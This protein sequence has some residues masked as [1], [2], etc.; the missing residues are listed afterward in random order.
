MYFTPTH[1]FKD[2]KKVKK[3]C[4]KVAVEVKS[5]RLK[6]DGSVNCL[7]NKMTACAANYIHMIDAYIC[8]TVNAAC[9]KSGINVS[10]IH[11]CWAVNDKYS[12][13]L[14]YHYKRGCV[15]KKLM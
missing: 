8:H 13:F 9:V 3:K 12:S 7:A 5:P 11:D 15:F 10:S 14:M 1:V 4:V 2:Q 6:K